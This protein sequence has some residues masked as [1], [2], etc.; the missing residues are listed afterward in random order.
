MP[1]EAAKAVAATFC[2]KIRY[3]LTPL[4]GTDF[5]SQ[6]IPPQDRARF[7]RM[8]IDSAIVRQATETANRYRSLELQGITTGSD[9]V[10]F[11]NSPPSPP[12]KREETRLPSLYTDRDLRQM[13]P[14]FHRRSYEDSISSARGSSSEPFCVSPRSPT[15]SGWTPVNDPPRSSE[16]APRARVPSPQHFY[17]HVTA[18]RKKHLSGRIDED[19]E[20]GTDMSSGSRSDVIRTPE[21]PAIDS[22]EDV[23]MAEGRSDA[24]DVD[25]NGSPSDVSDS[26]DEM[27][28]DDE[29]E[30]YRV[31]TSRLASGNKTP[32]EK[33]M[34]K[35]NPSRSA[36]GRDGGSVPAPGHFAHEVR[37]AHALLRLHMQEATSDDPEGESSTV[38]PS[39]GPTLGLGSRLSINPGTRKRRRAS[40]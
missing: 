15:R 23:E 1:F 25:S 26:D 31:S 24:A 16:I 11:T 27:V 33:D 3:I 18:L 20:S 19:S 32:D 17:A 9:N 29:D 22:N 37:A 8:I 35:K 14:K 30:E 34:P 5:P 12:N 38:E 2:W 28:N 13:V 40:L 21:F 39:W 6:C 7:G 4:F 10:S 36:K